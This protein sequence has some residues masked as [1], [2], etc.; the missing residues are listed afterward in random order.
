MKAEKQLQ[1][2]QPIVKESQNY[3]QYSERIEALDSRLHILPH[4]IDALAISLLESAI[5]EAETRYTEESKHGQHVEAKLERGRQ[6]GQELY[7]A[8]QNDSAMRRIQELDREI[9]HAQD[10]KTQKQRQAQNYQQIARRLHLETV[11]N[12][13]QF[14]EN[15][16]LATQRQ[17]TLKEDIVKIRERQ[18]LLNLEEHRLKSII[19]E[20]TEEI[21]PLKQRKTQIPTSELRLRKMICEGLQI[22]EDDFPFIG[23]LLQVW[24]EA[25]EWQPAVERL[26]NGFARQML[27]P[28][29]HYKKV[30]QWVEKTHLGGRLIY[31]RI[32]HQPE[33]VSDTHLRED[34][35]FYKMHVHPETPFANWLKERLIRDYDYV[36]CQDQ[37][38]LDHEERAIT[39]MGQIKHGNNRYEKDDRRAL[40]DPRNYV[41]GWNNQE[42]VEAL[43]QTLQENIVE[44]KT[45]QNELNNTEQEESD[46]RQQEKLIEQ[47]LAF[48]EFS[49]LDVQTENQLLI[50]YEQEKKSLETSSNAFK[51][52][53]EQHAQTVRENG[54]LERTLRQIREIITTSKNDLERHR[55][56]FQQCNKRLQS[57]DQEALRPEFSRIYEDLTVEPT[58][59]NLEELRRSIEDSYQGS[60]NSLTGTLT[61]TRQN[62]ERIMKEYVRIYPAETE[63]VDSDVAARSWYL[64]RVQQLERDDLP[65]YKD[66]FNKLL[67]R[68]ILQSITV[69]REQ[70]NK[71]EDEIRKSI[72]QLNESLSQIAYTSTTYI[73][74]ITKPT[75]QIEITDFKQLLRDTF[76]NIGEDEDSANRKVFNYIKALI[77]RFEKDPRWTTLVTDV[78]NWLDFSAEERYM[79]DNTVH[80]RY[81]SS[82]GK[83]G[84]QK[85][86]LAYTILASA[87]AYQYGLNEASQRDQTFR[88]VVIDEVFSKSD[89]ANSRFAMDLF[90]QLGLQVLVVTPS[91]KIQVVEPYIGSCHLVWNNSS[92]TYSQV[93]TITIEQLRQHRHQEGLP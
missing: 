46:L 61:R 66:A 54:E 79:S 48:T 23:E 53:Q 26:L 55:N 50:Q 81:Q 30:R 64:D 47:L 31:H 36:C 37:S 7:A 49:H 74:L 71:R 15:Q 3:Q 12:Q 72:D 68:N 83:S 19:T 9:R 39:L 57:V 86:K 80:E 75:Q 28:E 51:T 82:S 69:F 87:I 89:E 35:L 6:K 78:R 21:E 65:A 77:E 24:D 85:A 32:Q 5:Q 76:P 88:F 93:V 62:I 67:N 60:R 14:T 13:N 92:G 41:L 90:K 29:K 59:D 18:N 63:D 40:N 25:Y 17:E 52:L 33:Y 38:Q 91:D 56:R 44:L 2:L 16:I 58:L 11:L 45:V 43:E 27:V 10:R 73:K 1:L 22:G 84:G 8:I 70:L 34:A 42:K 20:R 4:F